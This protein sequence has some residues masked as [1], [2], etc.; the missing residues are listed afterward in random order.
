MNRE[1]IHHRG[2]QPLNGNDVYAILGAMFDWV[3][4]QPE[5]DPDAAEVLDLL[6]SLG[7]CVCITE[8]G[9]IACNGRNNEDRQGS[10]NMPGR[11]VFETNEPDPS[12]DDDFIKSLAGA[13]PHVRLPPLQEGFAYE[14]QKL[15]SGHSAVIITGEAEIVE[16]DDLNSPESRTLRHRD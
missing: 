13:N 5:G 8:F 4:E 11:N 12:P 3:E 9:C 7:Y 16:D 2:T 15:P 14:I 10:L 6:R 1:R